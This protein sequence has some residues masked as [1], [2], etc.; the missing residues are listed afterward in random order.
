MKRTLLAA[1]LVLFAADVGYGQ[2]CQAVINGA[3]ARISV[4]QPKWADARKVLAEQLPNC[5]EIAEFHYLYAITLAQ[6]SPDSTAK[7][8]SHLQIAEGLIGQ[9]SAGSKDA[10]LRANVQQALTALWGPMVNEGVRLLQANRLDEAQQ[11]LE[12]AVRLNPEGKEGHFALGAV[13]QSRKELD[14]AIEHYRRALEIDPQYQQA[15]IRLGSAYQLQAD[16]LLSSGDSQQVGQASVVAQQAIDLYE[17]FLEGNPDEVEVQVQLAG[18]Y[19]TLDQH[20]KAEPIILRIMQSDSVDAV[21]LTDFGFRMAN[22]HQH[23]LAEELLRRAVV[24]TDSLSVEPIAY[25]VFVRIQK[26]ELEGARAL[27]KKQVEL[28]PSNAQAWEYLALVER[29]LGNASA[30]HEALEKA[31]SIPL[32]LEALR[33]DQS[34]DQKWNVEA[35]FSNRTEIPVR[36]IKILFTMISE[37]GQVLETREAKVAGSQPLAAGEAESISVHFEMAAPNPRIKYEIVM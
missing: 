13:Y 1:A 36:D 25:L 4:Q 26:G 31:E 6:V 11:K 29:D 27:L 3:K 8:A 7:A 15:L 33:L 16:A 9:P 37:G 24:M 28:E 17:K 35:T 2:T 23:D 14:P 32:A 21:V 5:Q 10:E 19:A 34:Q 22:A 12:A 30:A 18:L 20:D